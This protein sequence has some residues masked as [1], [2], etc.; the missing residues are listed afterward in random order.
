MEGIGQWVC[1][2]RLES[3]SG[4]HQQHSISLLW[5]WIN[6]SFWSFSRNTTDTIFQPYFFVAF[7]LSRVERLISIF[8]LFVYNFLCWCWLCHLEKRQNIVASAVNTRNAE[9]CV[10]YFSIFPSSTEHGPL[11]ELNICFDFRWNIKGELQKKKKY[12]CHLSAV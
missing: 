9:R 12:V 1:L 6:Q 3:A 5:Q 4:S 2:P 10:S 8:V 7:P 11:L